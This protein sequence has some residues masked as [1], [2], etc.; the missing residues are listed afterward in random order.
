MAVHRGQ[1]TKDT[2]NQSMIVV[3][4]KDR[5][6]RSEL[7]PRGA[8]NEA[9][10]QKIV[11]AIGGTSQTVTER[12]YNVAEGTLLQREFPINTIAGP[13]AT[14]TVI[15]ITAAF[16]K[17]LQP[18]D[19]LMNLNTLEVYFVVVS[20]TVSGDLTVVRAWETDR[21]NGDGSTAAGDVLRYIGNAREEGGLSD[22]S[23]IKL[24]DVS[25]NYTQFVRTSVEASKHEMNTLE[26]GG[27]QWDRRRHDR[28][29]EHRAKID[30]VLLLGVRAKVLDPVDGA[31]YVYTTGGVRQHLKGNV[32][33]LT[34]KGYGGLVT[35]RAMDHIGEMM[36]Q[37]GSGQKHIFCGVHFVSAMTNTAKAR[38][39][40]N[41]S[42]KK[43][44]GIMM[45]EYT[46]SCGLVFQIVPYPKMFTGFGANSA[47]T[48]G[49]LAKYGYILDMPYIETV[50]QKGMNT[51][52]LFANVQENDRSGQKDEWQTDIGLRMSP[53]LDNPYNDP[54]A[55]IQYSSPHGII[56]AFNSY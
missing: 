56:T 43:K 29:I 28:L 30:S 1:A 36:I 33:S 7:D 25:Y 26:Y 11:D 15:N 27:D 46:C 20:N 48:G 41:D 42:L 10:F 5:I 37:N 21:I 19:M 49:T 16:A 39:I 13:V 9:A 38:L 12:K 8:V 45:Q 54:A 3:D 47:Y 55:N 32:F 52:Q 6:F 40:V 44:Y 50:G 35:E 14:Q 23:I 53:G 4:M 17:Q 18:R 24:V 22:E 34:A 2:D 31:K 51:T